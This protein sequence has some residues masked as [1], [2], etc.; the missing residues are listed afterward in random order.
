VLSLGDADDA[1]QGDERRRVP[2][3]RL[4]DRDGRRYGVTFPSM[5]T[6]K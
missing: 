5:A 2:L 1:R 4:P 3:E 6:S